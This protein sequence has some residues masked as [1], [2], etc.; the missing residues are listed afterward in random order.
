MSSLPTFYTSRLVLRELSIDDGPSYEKHFVDY[1]V[2]R[3]MSAA[4][5]WSYP[6]NG[7]QEYIRSFVAP[8]QGKDRW[9][10]GIAE[11]DTPNE[12]IGSVDLWRE[13][14]PENR[15]FWLGY[16]Y[17]GRGYITEAVEPV[18]HYAFDQLG[19]E[20]LVFTNAVGN[21]RSARIKQK[22]GARLIGREPAQY[23][24]SAFTEREVYELTKVDWYALKR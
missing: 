23:V 3:N 8:I 2:I 6:S 18:M 15:G 5:P 10:W 1:R 21:I 12:V 16:H 20:K 13:G 14:K 19:F 24:D 9:I 22:T 7:V 4:V 11:K 17:W